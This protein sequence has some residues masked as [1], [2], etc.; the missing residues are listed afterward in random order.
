NVSWASISISGST[1]PWTVAANVG[2]QARSGTFIIAGQSVAVAEAASAT[3]GTLTLNRTV[4]NFGTSGSLVTSTQ[5]VA[6]G[7]AGGVG[8]AWTVVSSQPNI[9]VSAGRT[10]DGGL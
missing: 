3:P 1:A 8:V 6:V 4:L 2:T 5:T 10:G 9:T 7:F